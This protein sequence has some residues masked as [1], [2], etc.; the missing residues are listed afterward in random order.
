MVSTNGNGHKNGT[1]PDGHRARRM[2]TTPSCGTASRLASGRSW[3]HQSTPRWCRSGRDA[4][5]QDLLVHRGAYRHRRGEPRLRLRRLGLRT[6]RAT[7]RCGRSTAWTPRRARSGASAPTPPP[8]ASRCWALR[9]AWT[10][11]STP[12]SRTTPTATRRPSRAPSRTASSGLCAASGRGSATALYADAPSA[13]VEVGKPQ[14]KSEELDGLRKRVLELGREQ[15]FEDEQV[16]AAVRAR[17]GRGIDELNAG[18][19]KALAASAEKKLREAR[20]SEPPTAA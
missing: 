2:G 10:W 18:E 11:A 3:T 6:R 12:S 4:R 13:I 17:T 16:A 20:E 7:W 15:G 14:A 8:C 5:R 1:K 9:L 19:L